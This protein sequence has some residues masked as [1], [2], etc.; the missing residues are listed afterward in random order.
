MRAVTVVGELKIFERLRGQIFLARLNSAHAA[1]AFGD[2]FAGFWY[3]IVI[4]SATA[5][6]GLIFLPETKDRTI[7]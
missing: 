5:L 6:V 1:S 7:D 4:A 2:I 3:S